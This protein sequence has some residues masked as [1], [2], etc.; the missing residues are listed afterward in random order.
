MR[1]GHRSSANYFKAVVQSCALS[2]DMNFLVKMCCV[3]DVCVNVILTSS[4]QVQ[5]KL[6]SDFSAQW[7]CPFMREN[8]VAAGICRDRRSSRRLDFCLSLSKELVSSTASGQCGRAKHGQHPGRLYVVCLSSA[9]FGPPLCPLILKEA[10][11][12]WLEDLAPRQGHTLVLIMCSIFSPNQQET[13]AGH[14]SWTFFL[15]TGSSKNAKIHSVTDCE[16]RRVRSVVFADW[17]RFRRA[18]ARLIPCVI[19]AQ[20]VKPKVCQ[21][22]SSRRSICGQRFVFRWFASGCSGGGR[23]YVSYTFGFVRSQVVSVRSF[24]PNGLCHCLV[25]C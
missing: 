22:C 19:S 23:R 11:F 7:Q 24:F 6:L 5:K 18:V 10:H 2:E 15:L 8:F 25:Q 4:R 3:F 20:V 17:T 1:L 9:S 12:S 14:Q 13:K 16:R 21:V